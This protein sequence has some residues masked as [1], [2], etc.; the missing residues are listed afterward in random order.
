MQDLLPIAVI[1]SLKSQFDNISERVVI[2]EDC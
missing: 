1:R 2:F